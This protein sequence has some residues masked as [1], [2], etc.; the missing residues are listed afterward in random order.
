[1][2]TKKLRPSRVA[3]ATSV[4]SDMILNGTVVNNNKSRWHAAGARQGGGSQ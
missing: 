4:P 2:Y 1:M 3:D